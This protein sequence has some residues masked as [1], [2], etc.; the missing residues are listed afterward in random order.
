MDRRTRASEAY[1]AAAKPAGKPSSTGQKKPPL[2]AASPDPD[3]TPAPDDGFEK[4]SAPGTSATPR[5]AKSP[6]F[7]RLVGAGN[8]DRA[9][10]LLISM[11]T[12]RA[13]EVMAHL[14]EAEVEQLASAIIGIKTVRR[15]DVDR[16]D[17]DSTQRGDAKPLRGGA[18]VARAMLIEAFGEDDGERRFFRS[19][20][21]AP[22][23]HFDFL[24]ALEPGQLRA[25]LKDEPAAATALVI[26]HL[27]R[28]VAAKLLPLLEE[29][30]RAEIARRI[31]RMDRLG[32]DT[33]LRIEEAL[34]EKIRR[35]GSGRSEAAGGTATLAAILRHM[36]PSMG[37]AIIGE[38][39]R[40]D[41]ALGASVKDELY[42]VELLEQ[43]EPRDLHEV[44]AEFDDRDVALLLKGKSEA[45]RSAVLRAVS[46]RR[47]RDISDEYAH[48][49]A[50]KREDVDRIT[51]DV[52]LRVR[53]LEESGRLLV[54]RDDERYI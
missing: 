24:N 42:T 30:K 45:I 19:V 10:K 14:S 54:P 33:I 36:A 5:G 47:A 18:D 51:R 3:R 34:R 50:Q 1:K 52:L 15:S 9:A 13:A 32:R 11:G 6:G 21:N 20:P 22:A 37:D 26:A 16:P 46:E 41:L 53:E 7:A 48:L 38:L 17:V 27:D 28:S 43:L 40:A 39:E 44:L 49:G 25:A 29:P 31:A 2:P 35:Q 8:L 12:E 23:H 4:T